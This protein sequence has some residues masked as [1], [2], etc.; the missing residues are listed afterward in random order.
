MKEK[1]DDNISLNWVNLIKPNNLTERLIDKSCSEFII[2]PLEK[3]FGNT[4]ANSL[5]RVMISSLYGTSICAIKIDMLEHEFSALTNIKEDFVDIILNLKRVVFSGNLGYKSSKF[6]LRINEVGPITASMIKTNDGIS[7]INK[8]HVICHVSKKVD[9]TMHLIVCS[10]KG[11]K[12]S[13]E[14]SKLSLGNNFIYIDSLFAPVKRC[15]FTTHGSRIGSETE[16][17]KL[18]IIIQTN[19]SILPKM[20]L[21]LA[22]KIL[23]DQLRTFVY[24]KE[25]K[26]IKK[27][28]EKALL[29]DKNLLRKVIDLELSVR[30][31]NCLKNDG[32][33]YV[34]DLVQ[35]KDSDMLK[36]PNF[37][38]KS[39]NEIRGVLKSL[40]LSFGMELKNWPPENIEHVAKVYLEG[41]N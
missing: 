24:F 32:I 6:I 30:S 2:E 21:A 26:E 9:Y 4:F 36:T 19:G 38:K 16:Y 10:G 17:D 29:F 3:G 23:Q 31:Q 8:D 5:R 41:D 25:V 39:L 28:K 33:I 18:S 15:T 34:G 40:S 22:A 7:V 20:A 11:Y 37:G 14:N 1:F 13:D 12:T 27:P 35:K